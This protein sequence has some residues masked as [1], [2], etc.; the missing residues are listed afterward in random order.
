MKRRR[1]GLGA[2]GV[3]Y[4]VYEGRRFYM[5]RRGDHPVACYRTKKKAMKHLNRIK[6]A[7]KVGTVTWRDAIGQE[8]AEALSGRR[9]RR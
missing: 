6:R 2:R 8:R 4:C 9:R 7:G 5:P 1:R 3:D